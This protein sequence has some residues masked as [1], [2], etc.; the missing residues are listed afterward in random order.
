MKHLIPILILF[1]LGFNIKAQSISVTFNNQVQ[2]CNNNGSVDA[3]VSGG[4]SPYTY[5]WYHGFN[6]NSPVVST[7]ASLTNANAGYYLL[8]VTDA[9]GGQVQSYV[10]FTPAFNLWVQNVVNAS[11]PLNNGSITYFVSG[12]TPPYDYLWSTGQS[13][14][15]QMYDTSTISNLAPGEYGITV[16]DANGCVVSDLDS[17]SY[18]YSVS[19]FSVSTNSTVSNC[20]DGTA[21][22]SISGTGVAP[23]TYYW[24]TVPPQTSS[25]AIG[26]NGSTYP[27]VT[28]TDADGCSTNAYA[29]INFG[30]NALQVYGNESPA[31]CPNNNGSITISVSN[32]TSPYSYLWSNGATTQNVSNLAPGHYSVTITDN[33]GCYLQVEKYI[34]E[35]SNVYG[36]V[37]TTATNCSNN[38][39][40]ATV[41]V[42]GGTAPYTYLWTNGSNATTISNLSSGYYSVNITDAN[43]CSNNYS[44][45]GYVSIPQS[46][47]S[48]ISGTIVNDMDGNCSLNNLE[49][50]L[51][52]QVINLGNGNYASS[53]EQGYYE[54]STFG[55]NTYTVSHTPPTDWNLICPVANYTVT[56]SIGS[57]SNGN[58][59]YDQPVSLQNDVQVYIYGGLARPGFH[60][61]KYVTIVNNGTTTMSGTIEVTHDTP[62]VYMGS[63]NAIAYNSATKTITLSYN[64]LSPFGY[65]YILMDFYIPPS[66]PIGTL[67]GN[68]AIINPVSGDAT[69]SNNYD[70]TQFEV[71]GSYDPNIKEV[72]PAGFGAA[73][74]ISPTNDKFEYTIHFQNTGNYLA[75]TVVITDTLDQDLDINSFELLGASHNLTWRI[76]GPRI[77]TFTFSHINLPDSLSNEPGSHGHVTYRINQLPNLTGGTEIKN[78][79]YIYFD[80]NAPIVTNTTLNTIE[81]VG[82]KENQFASGITIN[83]NPAS[84]KISIVNKSKEECSKVEILDINGRLVYSVIPQGTTI[85][86][87]D[88]AAGVYILN[89]EY[90][91]GVYKEK[92]IISK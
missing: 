67:L 47:L 62:E 79:A 89:A 57:N 74:L 86:L 71:R 35:Y 36:S 12:A 2:P 19:S 25:T 66:I 49:T 14:T 42:G 68:T 8:M 9:I 26:L 64:N 37:S 92:L 77:V 65:Q 44:S 39:G 40:T 10:Y 1:L 27:M 17:G 30:P 20:N 29:N 73:G 28:V 91:S 58:D 75:E 5:E 76:N 18:V 72:S 84:D 51:P 16:T 41:N 81:I 60:Y 82:V 54:F 78:T 45:W 61:Y 11:C 85:Q 13:F 53:N 6:T 50:G 88:L 34:S 87:P 56:T 31:L 48:T 7:S 43:G 24:N 3:V 59:F 90:N 38:N 63:S 80:Y 23:Y 15:G 32:G 46:C 22:A 21:T 69:P 55:V 33:A 4:T 52:W 83:P 70:T